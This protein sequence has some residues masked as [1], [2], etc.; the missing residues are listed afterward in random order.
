MFKSKKQQK[1]KEQRDRFLACAFASAD[2]FI[3][4]DPFGTIVYATGAVKT[5]TGIDHG[6]L[7]GK[8]WL[9]I[10]E[11]EH[12]NLLIRLRKEAMP[13]IRQGPF[14]VDMNKDLGGQ[15]GI[16]TSIKLPGSKSFYVTLGLSNALLSALSQLMKEHEGGPMLTGFVASDLEKEV[17]LTTDFV[18]EADDDA[19]LETGYVAD[20][21]DKDALTTGYEAEDIREEETLT[22]GYEADDLKEEE[23]LTT[24]YVA[25]D[26]DKDAL[27]TG[28]EAEDI[29]KDALTTGYEAE[30][31][32]N[33]ALTTG[34]TPE[35]L[36]S[37]EAI[38][39][40]S[41]FHSEAKRVF[42]YAKRH[43]LSASMTVFEFN[44]VETIEDEDWPGIMSRISELMHNESLADCPPI[45]IKDRIYG[46]LHDSDKKMEK[47][48][49]HIEKISKDLDP[50]G[51]GITVEIKTISASLN[52][53][54]SDEAT[55]AL[56]HTISAIKENKEDIIETSLAQNMKKLVTSNRD[57]LSEFKGIIDRVDFNINFQPVITTKTGE[58]E[59]YEVLSRVNTGDIADW[60]L[61]GEDKGLAPNFDLAVLERTMNYIHFKAGTTRTRFAINISSKSIEAKGFLEK[62]HEQLARRDLSTRLLIEINNPRTIEDASTLKE[63]IASLKALNYEVALDKIMVD[64]ELPEFLETVEA[65]YLKI[66]H[67]T[68][69]R[70]SDEADGKELV[71][72]II[73]TCKKQKIKIVGQLIEEKKQLEFLKE[74]GIPC[75]Q[76]YL[77]GKAEP[78]PKFIP[79][80][81]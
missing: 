73:A 20:D 58:A 17:A 33:E 19:P 40:R 26:I 23:S 59:F 61:F 51:N 52:E 9:T 79:P 16:L 36:G 15:K 74:L 11:P 70:L 67:K 24:G 47:L 54:S 56:L 48:K 39:E 41:E 45:H 18:P 53:I 37:S 10:F 4:I 7:R 50:T 5:L 65:S 75:A 71:E 6:T 78:A 77:F 49:N 43:N 32:D 55:R 81:K 72:N 13:G 3:E 30:D 2:L 27:T 69:K 29:D 80:T 42:K 63:F 57:K 28:Y 34:F 64:Q 21:T 1:L 66:G 68:L 12:H 14:L 31:V 22:T 25:D 38:D 60:V 76:G 62:F 8:K 44:A 46:L 35:T